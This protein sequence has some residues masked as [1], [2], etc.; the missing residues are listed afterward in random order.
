MNENHATH[1]PLDTTTVCD[2]CGY[3]GV[4]ADPLRPVSNTPKYQHASCQQ[5]A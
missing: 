4:P 2:A 1:S 3:P 5:G